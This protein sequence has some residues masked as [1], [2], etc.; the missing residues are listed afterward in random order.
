MFFEEAWRDI[1]EF[2]KEKEFKDTAMIEHMKEVL[3]GTK[4]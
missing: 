1:V 4:K 2:L 3:D